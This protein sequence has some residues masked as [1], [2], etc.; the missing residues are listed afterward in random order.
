MRPESPLHSI[1]TQGERQQPWTPKDLEMTVEVLQSERIA[2]MR[3]LATMTQEKHRLI[4]QVA[5]RD[6]QLRQVQRFLILQRARIDELQDEIRRLN[7]TIPP[8]SG[9]TTRLLP[10]SRLPRPNAFDA[11]ASDLPSQVRR[12]FSA[13]A[14]DGAGGRV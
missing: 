5:Q 3:D 10:S 1:P 9:T 2:L 8:S 14:G 6:E 7:G 12:F 4:E 11:G 13:G